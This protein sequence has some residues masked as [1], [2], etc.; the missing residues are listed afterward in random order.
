[1]PTTSQ[2][3]DLPVFIQAEAAIKSSRSDYLSLF[4]PALD[5]KNLRVA[6]ADAAHLKA[7]TKA[8]KALGFSVDSIG[9]YTLSISGF[10]GLFES[11]FGLVL[12]VADPQGDPSIQAVSQA[13]PGTPPSALV[14]TVTGALAPHISALLFTPRAALQNPKAN[15]PNKDPGRGQLYLDNDPPPGKSLPELLGVEAT[16]PPLT[17]GQKPLDIWVIDTGLNKTHPWFIDRNIVAI[18]PGHTSVIRLARSAK[19][20]RESLT[21]I[22]LNYQFEHSTP[23]DTRQA[24]EFELRF[25][26]NTLRDEIRNSTRVATKTGVPFLDHRSLVASIPN[27]PKGEPWLK[28]AY[29]INKIINGWFLEL[30]NILKNLTPNGIPDASHGTG[31][32]AIASAIA[33]RARIFSYELAEQDLDIPATLVQKLSNCVINC[34]WRPGNFEMDTLAYASQRNFYCAT[35]SRAQMRGITVVKTSGNKPV[36]LKT[37]KGVPLGK[38]DAFASLAHD[39][40]I[41]VGGAFRPLDG[42]GRLTASDLCCA[43]PG[44]N[45]NTYPIAAGPHLCGLTGASGIGNVN[46]TD[47]HIHT[48]NGPDSWQ[49]FDGTSAAA[50]QVAAACARVKEVWPTISTPDLRAIL[51]ATA[52]PI[53]Y[54]SAFNPFDPDVPYDWNKDNRTIGVVNV[55]RAV[56]LARFCREV[57]NARTNERF[58]TGKHLPAVPDIIRVLRRE[59]LNCRPNPPN[60]ELELLIDGTEPDPVTGI[61]RIVKYIDRLDYGRAFEDCTDPIELPLEDDPTL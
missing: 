56:R 1:M 48:P 15:R 27:D 21:R 57:R 45:V 61:P 20:I 55:G 10:A 46:L 41:V 51:V 35:L 13:S 40:L 50:P 9:A 31:V 6:R 2:P 59:A 3:T 11:A 26:T 22:M 12:S 32:T 43:F 39:A 24:I 16:L 4:D 60:P 54:G 25:L 36:A 37:A 38:P 30:D 49:L 47:G 44:G 7:A 8:L 14:P 5:P 33:P 29:R 52:D 28:T 58:N 23:V 19:A 18:G 53:L 34:S 17:P 42:A